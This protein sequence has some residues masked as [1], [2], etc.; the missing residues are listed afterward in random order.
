[1]SADH[2]PFNNPDKRH[3][4]AR[5]IMSDESLWSCSNDASPF[6]SDEG[7]ES[8]SE[9]LRWRGRNPKANLLECLDW[10]LEG[11]TNEYND[12]LLD[13]ANMAKIAAGD[14]KGGLIGLNYGDI[15]TLDATII[16]T[17]L[18]QLAEEGRIDPE[19]KPIVRIALRR[20]SHPSVLRGW[21]RH[22]VE[23]AR[24]LQAASTAVESA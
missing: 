20:Q 1:M 7:S 15:F 12:R 13:E 9:F 10:I 8:Y 16:A 17:A 21:S 2:D 11:R 3:P 18:A 22:G 14:E 4:R 23:R 5:E 24:I 6:G 19:V